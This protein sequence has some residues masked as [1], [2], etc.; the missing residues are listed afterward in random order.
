MIIGTE[1]DRD[2]F[3]ADLDVC[4]LTDEKMGVPAETWL[5]EDLYFRRWN[6]AELEGLDAPV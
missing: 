3:K 6:L 1:M 5:A 4:L 2:R